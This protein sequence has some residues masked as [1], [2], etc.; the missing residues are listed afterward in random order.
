MSDRTANVMFCTTLLAIAF[1]TTPASSIVKFLATACTINTCF[2]VH[3]LSAVPD[4][5]SAQ[6][7]ACRQ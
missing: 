6:V 5:E 1:T 7:P 3:R 4:L 2:R